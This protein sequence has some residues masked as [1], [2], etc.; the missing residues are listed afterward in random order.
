MRKLRRMC[1]GLVLF[2]H[3]ADPFYLFIN[4][5][6]RRYHH[7]TTYLTSYLLHLHLDTPSMHMVDSG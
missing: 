7:K 3:Q 4:S 1:S 6:Q 2:V 5:D